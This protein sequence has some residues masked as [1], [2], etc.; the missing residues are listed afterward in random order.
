MH[1][2]HLNKLMPLAVVRLSAWRH[3]GYVAG[4]AQCY[5]H[6]CHLLSFVCYLV[7]ER[8]EPQPLA[9]L[10]THVAPCA[11]APQRRRQLWPPVL[12]KQSQYTVQIEQ[13]QY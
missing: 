13:R 4:R 2:R 5:A 6:P 7:N 10:L 8:L 1:L 9:S 11:I 12:I 3:V